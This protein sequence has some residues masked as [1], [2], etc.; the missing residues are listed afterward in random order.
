MP[1]TLIV[2]AREPVLGKVKTR[3]QKDLPAPVVLRL[4]KSFLKDVL[5]AASRVKCGRRVICYTGG[6]SVP[7]L[8][9][10][11]KDFSFSRQRGKDLGERMHRAFVQS[12]KKGS[13]KTV[14]IGTDVPDLRRGDI[15]EAFAKLDTHDVVLGPCGDG[16][17]YLVGLQKP[18]RTFFKT[19]PWSTD[20]VMQKTLKQAHKRKKKICLL[21]QRN[22]IDTYE[23][24][25]KS[26][27]LG[28]SVAI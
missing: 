18:E 1:T 2:F 8:R 4:Y 25:K 24:L 7:F 9:R 22:D 23:D 15:Q 10:F 13:R 16:G 11:K 20:K 3:L 5:R 6:R 12:Q 27:Y 14:I 17:Y 21:K 28:K 26:H 19:I